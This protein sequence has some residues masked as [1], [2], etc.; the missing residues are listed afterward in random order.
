MH[1]HGD[2]VSVSV[3]QLGDVEDP[4]NNNTPPPVLAAEHQNIPVEI[5]ADVE[6]STTNHD[7][8]AAAYHRL[9]AE[10]AAKKVKGS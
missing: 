3:V 4:T 6:T 8:A 10:H 7:D 9:H 1:F 5:A 2:E